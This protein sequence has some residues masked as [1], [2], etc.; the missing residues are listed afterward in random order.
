MDDKTINFEIKI[1]TNKLVCTSNLGVLDKKLK[2][3]SE[4]ILLRR[5]RS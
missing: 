4:S 1:N 3:I 5:L 2:E